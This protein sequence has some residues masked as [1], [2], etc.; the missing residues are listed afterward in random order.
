MTGCWRHSLTRLIQWQKYCGLIR[1]KCEISLRFNALWPSH[2]NFCGS[3]AAWLSHDIV[4]YNQHH[5]S[6]KK[7]WYRHSL[8]Q[9]KTVTI[10][11]IYE[12][13]LRGPYALWQCGPPTQFF[14]FGGGG[15]PRFLAPN[16][17]APEITDGVRLGPD[18]IGSVLLET[19]LGDLVSDKSWAAEKSVT[20]RKSVFDFAATYSKLFRTCRSLFK[21]WFKQV[22]IKTKVM[23]FGP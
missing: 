5:V 18:S 11:Q 6:S 3:H 2:P 8:K 17:T 1:I 22:L 13:V 7:F 21:I 16:K 19:C 9:K 12:S 10:H 23:E 14:F 20:C 15:M 4:Q